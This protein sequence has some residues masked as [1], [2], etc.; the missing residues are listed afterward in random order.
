MGNL[1]QG[2]AEEAHVVEADVSD[3]CEVG[4]DDVGA[5]ETATQS[6]LDDCYVDLLLGKVVKGHCS[7]EL[8]EG[9]VQGLEECSML[10]HEVDDKLLAHHRS[11]HADAL[12][13]VHQVGRGV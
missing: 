5:V 10:L 4:A 6:D 12:P 11:I 1:G 7:G 2:I 9:G 8:K 3:D 13:E